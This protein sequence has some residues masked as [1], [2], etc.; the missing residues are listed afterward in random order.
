MKAVK[1][2]SGFATLPM[3][4]PSP[5]LEMRL[6]LP[7]PAD[8][9]DA[10]V[11][12]LGI[13]RVPQLDGAS[14]CRRSSRAIDIVRLDRPASIPAAWFRSARRRSRPTA[15]NGASVPFRLWSALGTYRRYFG[16]GRSSK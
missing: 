4:V 1:P 9:L 3:Y 5:S 13:R 12:G 11:A 10:E 8:L 2:F 7:D 15:M 16:P 6:A 14:A